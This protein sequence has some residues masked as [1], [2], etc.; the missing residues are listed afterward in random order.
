MQKR[1][2]DLAQLFKYS[3]ETFK[4]YAGYIIGIMMTYYVLGIVPQVYF[5]LGAP[6]T[7]T[8]SSQLLSLCLTFIQ[9]YISLGFIKIMLLLIDGEFTRVADLFNN[10]HLFISYFIASF[11]YGIAVLIG[12]FLLIVPGIFLSIRLQFYPYF[13]IEHGDTAL[14]AMKKSYDLSEN[15]T[16]ELLLF[17]ILV[18]I[19]NALGMLLVG[20]GIVFTYPLT[21]MATAVI[22]KG[23][24]TK[25]DYIPTDPYRP[26]G[27]TA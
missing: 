9:L 11:L 8:I 12:L 24:V 18:V 21:T 17:G 6:E 14:T 4:K 25:A 26:A 7:P 16:L 3:Y 5:M 27:T 20:I 10:A 13:I 19:L 2:L 23:L 15:L 1:T 22:Y